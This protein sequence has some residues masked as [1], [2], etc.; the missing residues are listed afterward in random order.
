MSVHVRAKTASD[1]KNAVAVIVESRAVNKVEKIALLLTPPRTL[2]L[3]P[4]LPPATASDGPRKGDRS[5]I[6]NLH[7]RNHQL[8]LAKQT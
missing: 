2:P 4:R 8:R 5:W 1:F 3:H 7:C 6:H